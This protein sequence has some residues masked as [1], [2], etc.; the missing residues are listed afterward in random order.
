MTHPEL[1]KVV[2]LS[3]GCSKMPPRDDDKCGLTWK[4]THMRMLL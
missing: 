2:P 3:K 1:V 4:E